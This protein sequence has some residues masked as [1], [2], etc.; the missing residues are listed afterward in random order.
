MLKEQNVGESVEA[1][2]GMY[3][4]IIGVLQIMDIVVKYLF[5]IIHLWGKYRGNL[6]WVEF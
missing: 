5:V 4:L 2:M 3:L 1:Q 6:M